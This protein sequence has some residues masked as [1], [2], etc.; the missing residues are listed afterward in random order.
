VPGRTLASHSQSFLRQAG[1]AWPLRGQQTTC[2]QTEV[3]EPGD[4]L[5]NRLGRNARVGCKVEAS[6][7]RLLAAVSSFVVWLL[8]F[9]TFQPTAAI[10]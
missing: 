4:A 5:V 9:L 8:A 2:R 3:N 6:S 10:G 1:K 7:I